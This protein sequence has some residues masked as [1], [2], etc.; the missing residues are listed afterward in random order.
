MKYILF[1]SVNMVCIVYP[2]K[3]H[4]LNLE[5]FLT[6]CS[7]VCVEKHFFFFFLRKLKFKHRTALSAYFFSVY[8]QSSG[9]T[10]TKKVLAKALECVLTDLT[11]LS[12]RVKT[13]RKFF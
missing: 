2:Q 1:I 3:V 7:K 10:K 4:F 11:V 9:L 13:L 8:F 12:I 6:V 5:Y